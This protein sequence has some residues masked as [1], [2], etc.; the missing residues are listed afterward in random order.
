MK[1]E[2]NN[3]YKNPLFLFHGSP[4][5]L[6][7][8]EPRKAHDSSGNKYNEDCAIYLTPSIIMASAYAFKDKIKE[9]SKDKKWNFNIGYDSLRGEVVV[10]MENVNIDDDLIGYIYVFPFNSK[11][12]H[13]RNSLQYKC[14]EKIKPVDIIKVRFGDYK[15][16]YNI[17]ETKTHSL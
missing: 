4:K 15:K 13:Q 17:K 2:Y 3:D 8:I 10:E 5:L 9:M 16:Y 14:F 1:K 12:E 6:K 11:Y 7:T